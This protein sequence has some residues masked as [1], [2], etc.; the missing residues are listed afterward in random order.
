[1][2]E[3]PAW[4]AAEVL[5]WRRGITALCLCGPSFNCENNSFWNYYYYYY[6]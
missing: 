1:V 3:Q 2:G 6:Y 5:F 4:K